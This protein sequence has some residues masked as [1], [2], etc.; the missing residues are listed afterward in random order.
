V[1]A[2]SNKPSKLTRLTRG[3]RFRLT[4][5]YVVF[6]T[7][8]LTFIGI[9]FRQT[10]RT[11]FY[12]QTTN[13]LE[14]EWGAVKGYLRI[15]KGQINWYFD[16]E[17]PEEALI[18][19][20]L[21]QVYLLTDDKGN[22]LETNG[23][24]QVGIPTPKEI[25]AFVRAP[26]K[27]PQTANL[28]VK[29]NTDGVPFL[30]RSGLFVDDLPPRQFYVAIGRSL[31]ERDTIVREFTWNYFIFVPVMI[32]GC[33]LLGWVISGRAIAP[34]NDVARTA[35]RITSSNLS[36]QIATRGA[37]D[38]LDRLIRSFNRM[39]QRLNESFIQTRQ[40]S[41]DVSHELRT[42]LTAIRGQLEVAMF[43]AKT[44]EQYR[45]AIVD[46]LQDVERLS[47]TI[48]ALL[49]LSQAESGQLTL[50]KQ[51]VDFGALVADIVDQF[52]IP[53]DDAKLELTYNAP[54]ECLIEGDKIQLERLVSNL[55]S[56]AVKYTPAGGK[57]NV[58]VRCD[59]QQVHFVIADTGK[60]I[61]PDHL[62][63][64]FDRFYRVPDRNP[65]RGL[66]LGLSFVAWIVKVHK[67]KIDVDSRI[68]AGTTF[69]VSLPV[70][71]I[72]APVEP[73]TP[74]AL[75]QGAERT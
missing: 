10:L 44:E 43:T 71:N 49:L 26:G 2:P 63:H 32:L 11:I 24:E 35:Q 48:R 64:I 59:G 33:S 46:A 72:V 42:P 34:V 57:I 4:F 54:P 18:V 65:E 14:E 15:E 8:L 19:D 30:I 55:L 66:G 47:Q 62:P 40:F 7:V 70:G 29:Y 53:A 38:E 5:G 16:A 3:L 69:T 25:Q 31:A 20:R 60:G 51:R 27:K 12:E 74:P 41:T 21:K 22:V 61:P 1:N 13:L 37:D 56:N 52:Q 39:T 75:P 73:V 67:G 68:G 9:F 6:F 58:D 45:E 36:T 23:F 17:D 28:Q 50:Q